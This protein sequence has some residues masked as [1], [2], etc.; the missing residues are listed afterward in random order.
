MNTI[1]IKRRYLKVL[2][3]HHCKWAKLLHCVG[4]EM[5]VQVVEWE[6]IFEMDV[7]GFVIMVELDGR[8]YMELGMED[9]EENIEDI[10]DGF[11]NQPCCQDWFWG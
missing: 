9:I 8:D 11:H 5:V 4:L 2:Y 6:W 1:E 7:V 3:L 10:V